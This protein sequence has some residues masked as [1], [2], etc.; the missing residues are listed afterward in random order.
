MGEDLPG[1]NEKASRRAGGYLFL[2]KDLQTNSI[3]TWLRRSHAWTGFYGALFFF[4]L[5]LTGF[6]LNHRTSIMHIEGGVTKEV[7]SLSA[8]VE[9]GLITSEETL[10]AWIQEEFSIDAEPSRG[11]RRPGGPVSFGGRAAE[12]APTFAVTFRGPN[13]IITGEYELGANRVSVKRSNPSL[14]KG[15]I[16][17]H[18]V[19]GVNKVFILIMDTM[20]GAMMFMVM[21][22]ILLWTRLHGPR[23][24]AV[25]ILGAVAMA[26]VIALSGTWIGWAA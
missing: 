26:T 17:L 24:A 21:S 3:L 20:A 6:Y 8:P 13:G 23:L 25:G 10:T 11:R 2:P 5:G 15:L 4:V 22:G 14:L 19:A 1:K 7:A 18:K 12:Q 9:P 16:D